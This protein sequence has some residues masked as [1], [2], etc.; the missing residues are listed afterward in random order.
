MNI[1]D[2]VPVGSCPEGAKIRYM[3]DDLRVRESR[4]YPDM[5]VVRSIPSFSDPVEFEI[6]ADRLVRFL[7]F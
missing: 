2:V 4:P 3:G 5:C 1:G 6:C 7:G